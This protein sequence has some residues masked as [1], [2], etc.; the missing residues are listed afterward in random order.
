EAQHHAWLRATVLASPDALLVLDERARVRFASPATR[1]VLGAEPETLTGRSVEELVVDPERI[2]RWLQELVPDRAQRMETTTATRPAR[3][4]EFS[5]LDLRGD[6]HIA[7]IILSVRDVTERHR[8]ERLLR[9]RAT[10]DQLTGLASRFGFLE[11]LEGLLQRSRSGVLGVLCCDL[12]RFSL[13][14]DAISWEAGDAA[15]RAVA[16]RLRSVHE[17]LAAARLEADRFAVALGAPD[18]D[19]LLARAAALVNDLS[20]WYEVGGDEVFL[21]MRGGFAVAEPGDAATAVLRRAEIAFQVGKRSGRESLAVFDPDL[22]QASIDRQLL[23]RD[24]RRAL[25]SGELRVHY[26]PV[27]ELASRRVSSL[28]A[29]VRWQHPT[30]GAVSPAVFVPL[31]EVT[32]L[33]SQLTQWVLLEASRQLR[34]WLRTGVPSDLAVSVNLSPSDFLHLD[35]P[36]LV[37]DVLQVTG[38]GPDQ[39]TLELTESAMLDPA[40]SREHLER[41]RTLG[42]AVL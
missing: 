16:V 25:E 38:I 10:R 14:N 9:E 15:L 26:Q 3:V 2:A 39:L 21:R 35:V 33:V 6:P 37:A 34:S 4:L 32:G 29:L 30:R 41:L 31:A 23:E 36:Q 12:A 24:L 5:G 8:A 17:A 42:V 27:F 19:T 28:E 22:Y 7:G 40:V 11:E 20:G 1:S 13:L 18:R